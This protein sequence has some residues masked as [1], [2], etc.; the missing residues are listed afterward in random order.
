M[1]LV[2]EREKIL[3]SYGIEG[4]KYPE[5]DEVRVRAGENAKAPVLDD[6]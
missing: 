3:D 5:E 1:P 6:L 2:H 4:G